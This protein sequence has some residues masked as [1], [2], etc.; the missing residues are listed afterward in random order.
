[1]TNVN[2]RRLNPPQLWF[3][4][5]ADIKARDGTWDAQKAVFKEVCPL[6]L[7]IADSRVLQSRTGDL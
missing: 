7:D 2:S 4:K 1:M 5:G 6:F 3:G